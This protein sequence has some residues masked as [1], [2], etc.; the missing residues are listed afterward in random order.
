[1]NNTLKKPK[2][3]KHLKV[4]QQCSVCRKTVFKT[5]K[6]VEVPLNF[7]INNLTDRIIKRLKKVGCKKHPL[8][9]L[10]ASYSFYHEEKL[11]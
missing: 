1:M 9:K 6:I 11:C 3:I 4:T 10:S 5:F 7:S 2:T 8:A